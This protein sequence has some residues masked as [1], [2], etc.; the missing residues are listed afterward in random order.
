[1]ARPPKMAASSAVNQNRRDPTTN[2]T[3][4]RR[5]SRV[6]ESQSPSAQVSNHKTTATLK[7]PPIVQAMVPSP[8][9]N[10]RQPVR[11]RRFGQ[12]TGHGRQLVRITTMSKLPIEQGLVLVL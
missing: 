9:H 3:I 4:G 2:D 1:V 11:L 8:R 12:E 7:P 6:V 10:S 5:S